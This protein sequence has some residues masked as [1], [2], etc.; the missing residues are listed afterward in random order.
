V[1]GICDRIGEFPDAVRYEHLTYNGPGEA[2]AS[3]GFHG[4]R[5]MDNKMPISFS[6]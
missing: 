1:D 4:L 3:D 2:L 5:R 6:T